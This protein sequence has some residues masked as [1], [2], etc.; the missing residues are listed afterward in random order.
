M[1]RLRQG[2][3]VAKNT[4]LNGNNGYGLDF[5]IISK[6]KFDSGKAPSS[7]LV[8]SKCRDPGQVTEYNEFGAKFTE[9][10]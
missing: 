9:Q 2:F 8:P 10:R 6:V 5:G 1:A 4:I 3:I 7:A